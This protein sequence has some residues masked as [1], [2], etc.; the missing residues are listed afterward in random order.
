[1]ADGFNVSFSGFKEIDENLERLGEVAGEKVIRSSLFT[2]I[3]PIQ[4]RVESGL[5]AIPT[6]SGALKKA[7]R[8]VYLRPGSVVGGQR[9]S[10]TRFVV[11]VAPKVKDQVAVALANLHYKR[12]RPIRGVF[13]GHLLEWGHRLAR[14]GQVRGRRIF[15]KAFESGSLEAA[16]I[17]RRVIEQRVKSALK[18]AAKR[19]S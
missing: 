5:A 14:G 13:W 6:G 12:K 1:V 3:K 10:N 19:K 16:S 4:D 7:V 15:T 11:A 2:A 18:R 8:R 9:T 17:F